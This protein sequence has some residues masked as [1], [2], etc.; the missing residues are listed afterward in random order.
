MQDR[1]H[2]QIG[3]RGVA[4]AILTRLHADDEVR[5]PSAIGGGGELALG[6]RLG[7]AVVAELRLGHAWLR[8][9]EG[10]GRIRDLWFGIAG[11]AWTSPEATMSPVLGAAIVYHEASEERLDGIG[12]H[13]DLGLGIHAA[14][15]L[16]L[17]FGLRG[18]MVF[19]FGYPTVRVAPLVAVDL[20][21]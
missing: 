14:R 19:D 16:Y 17:T 1:A 3:L 13:L 8:P 9:T 20:T 6:G 18:G 21:L 10:D 15:H 7:G 5:V 11:S 4:P 12:L 2:A